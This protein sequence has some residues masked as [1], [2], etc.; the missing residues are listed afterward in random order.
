MTRKRNTVTLGRIGCM[1][2]LAGLVI[3]IGQAMP[4]YAQNNP[5]PN[6]NPAQFDFADTFYVNNG[7]DLNRINAAADARM[8]VN[9]P[10]TN[11]DGSRNW[12]R[13]STNTSPIHNDCRVN[14]VIAVFDRN[15]NIAFFNAMAVLANS[16]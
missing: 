11:P 5:D 2:A 13:D 9:V 3:A 1:V 16:D 14:Q 8:C 10:Q 4:A 12:V 15:G 6:K 7:M